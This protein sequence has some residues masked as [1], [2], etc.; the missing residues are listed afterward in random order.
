M[1][2]QSGDIV[3]LV[4]PSEPE[5]VVV[6]DE[7]PD[8]FKVFSEAIKGDYAFLAVRSF[9]EAVSTV[10][11][12]RASV[13]F[14]DNRFGGDRGFALCV[15]LRRQRAIK[16]VQIVIVSREQDE[17]SIRKGLEAG[18][19]DF[20]KKPLQALDLELRFKAAL[21]RLSAQRELMGEV[22]YYKQAVMQEESLSRALLDKHVSLKETLLNVTTVKRSLEK[23]NHRLETIAHIDSLTGLL[24]RASLLKR[25]VKISDYTDSAGL[26]LAGIMLDVDLFKMI[27]DSYGHIVG[28]SVLRELG[29]CLARELRKN[30]F[31]GRYGGEEFFLVLPNAGLNDSRVIAERIGKAVK[32][33]RFTADEEA[34]FG[35]SVSMGITE[36]RSGENILEWINRADMAMYRSKQEGRDRINLQ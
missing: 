20:L 36:Y 21:I 5:A 12:R 26:P 18:A 15:E 13:V 23:A 29:K 28:D 9:E 3:N 14:I 19:D 2:E 25:M 6:C 11:E 17:A 8:A 32:E 22:E 31:A 24:N 7:D 1:A 35:I 10:I 4:E 34:E 33:L 30:D 16:P 27:N